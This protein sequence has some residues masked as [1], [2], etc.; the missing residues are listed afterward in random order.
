MKASVLLRTVTAL[1]GMALCMSYADARPVKVTALH[2]FASGTDG[3]NPEARLTHY[4][5]M[6]Y[7]TT[8]NGGGRSGGVVFS[9]D[10]KTGTETVLHSFGNGIDGLSPQAGLIVEDNILYGVASFGGGHSGGAVFALDLNTGT[11]RTVYGFC[12]EYQCADGDRPQSDLIDVDGTLYGTT[13]QGGPGN[14]TIFNGGGVVFAL[15]PVTGVEKVVHSF[16]GRNDGR[17]PLVGLTI[18]N[19]TY[20]GTTSRGGAYGGGTAYSIDLQ[21]GTEKILHSFG[22]GTDGQEPY[23]ALTYLNGMLYGVTWNGGAN[24]CGSYNCGT[25][26]SIDPVSGA[27]TVLHS[28]AGAD[29]Y[30]PYAAL[31]AVNGI[32]YGTT[33]YG[34]DTD[35]GTIFAVDP[36]T[37]AFTMI[38]SFTGPDGANPYAS[39][40]AVKNKLYGTTEEGGYYGHG[41]VY[42]FRVP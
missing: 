42:A 17:S 21:T 20:F 34:G 13:V 38:H 23:G 25:V 33:A 37:G 41:T 8:E 31:I 39:L 26:F 35:R 19:G 14:L 6:L 16:N 1:C 40:I 18:N 12:R 24:S 29:G 32:L 30:L 3:A 5:G 9:L 28:F 15:D 36:T 11:E 27:E 22:S 4:N 7:G 10:P 2:A